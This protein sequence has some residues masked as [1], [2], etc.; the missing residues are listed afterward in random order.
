M[1][2]SFVG[3][4]L[5]KCSIL[6]KSLGNGIA[7][8]PMGVSMREATCS[9]SR[10]SLHL[11]PAMSICRDSV[12][13]NVTVRREAELGTRSEGSKVLLVMLALAD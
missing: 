3:N 2:A 9:R 4:A 11:F 5:T 10:D 12:I 13:V 6:V 8:A 1:F 7:T